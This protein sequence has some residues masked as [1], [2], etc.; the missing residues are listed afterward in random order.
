MRIVPINS[1][2]EGAA[3]ADNLYSENGDIL[4]KKGVV[5][6]D[7]LI[8]RIRANG[9]SSLYVHDGFINE[10]IHDI[11]KP[12]V[13]QKAIKAIRETFKQIEDFNTQM[14]SQT[15]SFKKRIHI[16]SMD[17]Y[18]LKIK[19][20]SEYIVDD[21]SLSHQLMVNLVDIKNLN[22]YLYQHALN[23][24]LLS[25][26]VGIEMRLN[27]HQLYN[28]FIGAVLHDIGKLFI[29]PQIMEH[30][31]NLSEDDKLVLQEHTQLGYRYL[32]DNYHFEAPTKLIA[33]EHHE[34]VDGTGYPKGLDEHVIHKFAKIV[35]VCNCYD[36]LTSDTPEHTA[37]PAH[38]A[39]EY[40]M[41]NGGTKFDFDVVE[42]FT[43]KVNPYPVGTIVKLSDNNDYIVIKAT[44]NFP[45]RPTVKQ[46]DLIAKK[47][48]DKQIN[49]LER[50]D[51][52]V[53]SVI[54]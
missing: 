9:I 14:L 34:H 29:D 24:A 54:Q 30:Q 3:L 32:C 7:K 49:L 45:T 39:L 19:G 1:V 51:L 13:K 23:V 8:E 28:L 22:N 5:L 52:V 37:I 17:N 35:A 33:L 21:I 31:A 46:V 11:I 25:T 47:S 20:I 42:I 36:D 12:E 27:K 4:L 43:R 10:E 15:S 38:E 40:I 50:N 41:A 16:K 44:P 2:K 53:S 6:S 26:V 18:L 48:L